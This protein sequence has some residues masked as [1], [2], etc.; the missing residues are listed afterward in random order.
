MTGDDEGGLIRRACATYQGYLELGNEVFAADGATF[1]RN[2][3]CRLRHDANFVGAVRAGTQPEIAALLER[4]E[5]EFAGYG[6]RKFSI[7]PL[8]PLPL[9]ARLIVEGYPAETTVQLLLESELRAAP[10]EV[11]LL[12]V[13]SEQDWAAYTR[14]QALDWSESLE[15]AGRAETGTAEVLSHFTIAKRAKSPA[16]RTWL[17]RADGDARAYFSSWP[18][19]DG[20]GMIEDLFTQREYRHRGI[21]TALIAHCVADARARGAREVLIGADAND[22]PKRMYAAMGFRPLFTTQSYSRSGL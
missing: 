11:D 19:I 8:T 1:V 12:L 3:A 4:V 13:E 5:R 2:R 20:L 10:R 6:H 16:V 21:A 14:L 17:A 22:T 15:K 9:S 18:G 7:D